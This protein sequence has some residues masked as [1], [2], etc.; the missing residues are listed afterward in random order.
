METL[1]VAGGE[2]EKKDLATYYKNNSTRINI[3]AVD[4]GLEVL[5]Q[6]NLIPNHVVG[7]FDSVPDKIL[8]DYQ[9]NPQVIFHQ[10]NAEKDNTDTD[11]AI[12]LAIQLKSSK[13][14][15]MGAL[16]KRMDHAMANIHILKYALEAKIPCQ[17]LDRYN[18]IYLID[19]H[20]T[21]YKN[22]TY[23]KYISF[24]PLTT[25]VEGITLN[26]FKYPL[27][28]ASLSIGLSLGISNEIVEEFATIEVKKGILVTIESKD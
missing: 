13:I 20:Y 8:Q 7:D 18:K 26:G 1:I 6:L 25:T 17:I 19:K 2:I 9:D 14:T 11:I 22:K 21:L 3:I 4:R 24:I 12:Q 23:G 27:S 10:Y 15:I 28:D 16:G 5:Y